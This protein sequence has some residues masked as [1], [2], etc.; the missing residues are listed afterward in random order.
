MAIDRTEISSEFPDDA[1]AGLL[2]VVRSFD[3]F[4]IVAGLLLA[5]AGWLAGGLEVAGL[6]LVALVVVGFLARD[7]GRAKGS[8]GR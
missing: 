5:A 7:L 3:V 1:V 2:R 6:G 4:L 8:A